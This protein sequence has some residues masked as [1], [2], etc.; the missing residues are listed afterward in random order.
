MRENHGGAVWGGVLGRSV[1][2]TAQLTQFSVAAHFFL[3]AKDE[4]ALC[5]PKSVIK[6]CPSD[7]ERDEDEPRWVGL[8]EGV[9]TRFKRSWCKCS[10]WQEH[11]ANQSPHQADDVGRK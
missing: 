4:P 2:I 3:C 1:T 5:R 8:G 6:V 11:K 10:R 9:K 7:D